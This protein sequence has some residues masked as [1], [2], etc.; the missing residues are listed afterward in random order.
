M[1]ESEINRDLKKDPVVETDIPK[2]VMT[3]NEQYPNH[4]S[5]DLLAGLVDV[6]GEN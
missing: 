4:M 1:L 3:R 2:R 6:Q 5:L